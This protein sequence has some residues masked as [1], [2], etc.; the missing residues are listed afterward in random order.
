MD[1][2]EVA[3]SEDVAIMT[4]CEM[5]AETGARFHMGGF[6]IE[7]WNLDIKYDFSM[8]M[9]QLS[10]VLRALVEGSE[11]EI[12]MYSQGVERFLLF[13]PRGEEVGIECVSGTS[14]VPVPTEEKAAMGELTAM[15]RQLATDFSRAII[16][17]DADGVRIEPIRRWRRGEFS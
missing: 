6:G 11:S 5:L 10:Q 2:P 14:W 7:E 9:E 16:K 17:M 4:A 13:H 15:L 12:S 8:F 1:S 3:E